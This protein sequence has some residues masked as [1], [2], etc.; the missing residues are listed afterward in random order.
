MC[1]ATQKCVTIFSIIL[2]YTLG[3]FLLTNLAS[4]FIVPHHVRQRD[5]L[6]LMYIYAI[7]S[8]HFLFDYYHYYGIHLITYGL[9]WISISKSNYTF[10]IWI[11]H[12]F[13]ISL[14]YASVLAQKNW[15][16]STFNMSLK[17][18][19]SNHYLQYFYINFKDLR[20]LISGTIHLKARVLY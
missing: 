19:N 4:A 5:W 13:L 20:A 1:G 8:P 14:K 12:F 10:S 17:F 18:Y 16:K 9:I 2:Q 11:I 7:W 3:V 6:Y 15:W